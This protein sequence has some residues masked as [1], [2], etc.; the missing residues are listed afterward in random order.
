MRTIDNK[1]NDSKK[2]KKAEENLREFNK[3]IKLIEKYSSNLIKP[4]PS[5]P[6][7]TNQK[8]NFY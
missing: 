6:Y 5:P 7:E 1:I 8:P 3:I 4:V 2:W